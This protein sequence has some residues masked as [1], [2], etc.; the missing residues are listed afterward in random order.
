VS[1]AQELA[2]VG[3]ALFGMARTLEQG[4]S[5]PAAEALDGILTQLLRV[6][7]DF[8][9]ALSGSDKLPQLLRVGLQALRRP[10]EKGVNGVL[11]NIIKLAQKAWQAVKK[12]GAAVAQAGQQAVGAV[13]GFFGV[14]TEFDAGPEHHSLYF[15]QRNGSTVLIMES[16]PTEI[17]EFLDHLE[18]HYPKAAAKTA[19]IAVI[20]AHLGTYMPI[21]Q[22]LADPG[23]SAARQQVHHRQLLRKNVMLAEM[24][25]KILNEREYSATV[26]GKSKSL[27]SDENRYKLEGM[28]GKFASQLDVTGDDFTFDHQPQYK[29]L[30]NASKLRV[31]PGSSRRLFD[32]AAGFKALAERAD[33]RNPSYA[34]NLSAI[35]HGAGRT[36]GLPKASIAS[37]AKARMD[38]V[39]ARNIDEQQKRDEVVEILKDELRT[40]VKAMEA[41]V[42]PANLD[43]PLVWGDIDGGWQPKVPRGRPASAKLEKDFQDKAVSEDERTALKKRIAARIRQGEQEL[44][45]QPMDVL[46]TK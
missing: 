26:N 39:V 29:S 23:L 14:R 30:E 40:D 38:A 11:D 44:L 5:K 37:A 19:E 32:P 41:V 7:L 6:A 25:K 42:S 46:K 1:R 8:W 35:R 20:R 10:V 27:A 16:T 2:R 21:Y 3:L 43:K 45:N 15:A 9:P 4:Q 22:Q 24:L 28:T 17:G 33:G 18:L 12:G 13:K 36:Y 31:A 34:I